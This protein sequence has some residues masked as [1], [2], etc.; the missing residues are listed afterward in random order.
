[1]GKPP[2]EVPTGKAVAGCPD[3]GGQRSVDEVMILS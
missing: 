3:H 2:R 1:M